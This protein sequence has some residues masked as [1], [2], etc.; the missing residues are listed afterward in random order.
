M[1]RLLASARWETKASGLIALAHDWVQKDLPQL[2]LN[3]PAKITQLVRAE[4]P[5]WATR[6]GY[7][8]ENNQVN[9][10]L[11]KLLCPEARE[12][13][14]FVCGP[15]NEWGAVKDMSPW[16]LHAS[17]SSRSRRLRIKPAYQ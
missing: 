15:F 12:N 5:L 6:S 7:W 4:A 14:L 17:L 3:P 16:S 9:F 2:E 11:W 10:F 1:Y 8:I 13:S